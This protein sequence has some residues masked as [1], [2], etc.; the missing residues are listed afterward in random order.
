MG[1]SQKWSL[2]EV[3]TLV[4][5]HTSHS[6][7]GGSVRTKLYV[8]GLDKSI[9]SPVARR[10]TTCSYVVARPTTL[11]VP[12]FSI[13]SLTLYYHYIYREDLNLSTTCKFI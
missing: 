9:F 5:G 3:V 6:I 13:R 4:K 10:A 8:T 1:L 7:L 2:S 11:V 12:T